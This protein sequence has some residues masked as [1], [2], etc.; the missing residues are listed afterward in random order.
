MKDE[1]KK[2]I[3]EIEKNW[4]VMSAIEMV[5]SKRFNDSVEEAEMYLRVM[6]LIL[7]ALIEKNLSKEE[8]TYFS[9]KIKDYFDN[10]YQKFSQNAE[11][12]ILTG[13]MMTRGEWYFE[14]SYD[15]AVKMMK[16]A[17]EIKPDNIICSSIYYVFEDQDLE[18]NSKIKFDALSEFFAEEA[19]KRWLE[20]KGLLGEYILGIFE[21]VFVEL[22][23]HLGFQ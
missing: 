14:K 9:E 17:V 20:D 5:D 4:D 2:R 10:S 7:D 22:K 6:F 3:S 18:V 16:K 13:M 1:W 21:N 23:I 19:N 11:Y 15:D 8:E 12:L